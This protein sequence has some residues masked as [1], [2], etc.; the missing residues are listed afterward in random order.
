MIEET[1]YIRCLHTTTT[2]TTFIDGRR[3]LLS[4]ALIMR[5]MRDKVG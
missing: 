2:T 1:L 3:T 4:L 5:D